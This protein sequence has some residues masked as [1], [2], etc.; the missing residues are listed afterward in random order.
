MPARDI[1]K[2][3]GYWWRRDLSACTSI[4]E[5]IRNAHCAFFHFGSISVFQGDVSPLSSRV[6][7]ESYVMPVLLF[8]CEN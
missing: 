8:G 4:D 6:V 1:G 5:N 2:C 7:L 3:L